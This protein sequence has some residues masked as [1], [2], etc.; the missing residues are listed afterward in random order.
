MIKILILLYIKIFTYRII[1]S[2]NVFKNMINDYYIQPQ[3]TWLYA[4][5]DML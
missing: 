3:L 5:Q 4:N 2:I 1:K